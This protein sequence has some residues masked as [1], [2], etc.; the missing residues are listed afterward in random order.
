VN[1]TLY[2]LL[3]E[4]QQLTALVEWKGAGQRKPAPQIILTALA[5]YPKSF[6]TAQTE[7]GDEAYVVLLLQSDESAH[8]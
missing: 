2:E 6:A 5:H 8:A 1:N 4:L 7:W 3:L